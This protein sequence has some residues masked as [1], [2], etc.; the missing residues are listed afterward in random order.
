MGLAVKAKEQ[1]LIGHYEESLSTFRVVESQISEYTSSLSDEME[2]GDPTNFEAA[3]K[4]YSE[5]QRVLALLQEEFALV[6]QIQETC[7][8]FRTL[9]SAPAALA[10]PVDTPPVHSRQLSGASAPLTDAQLQAQ[11]LAAQAAT[12]VRDPDVWPPPTTEAPPPRRTRVSSYG[13]GN[14]SQWSAPAARAPIAA[15]TPMKAP[16]ARETSQDGDDQ[17]S[18][19]LPDWANRK[20]AASAAAPAAAP[21]P[22]P[23]AVRKVSAVPVSSASQVAAADPPP[24][25]KRASMA[26]GA[27]KPAV[28]TVGRRPAATARKGA[29]TKEDEPA[30]EGGRVK[31]EAPTKEEQEMADMIER[32]ILDK[33]PNVKMADI[34]GLAGVSARAR[35]TRSRHPNVALSI[36]MVQC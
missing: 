28:P 36:C 23:K 2:A 26:P 24:R 15:R 20:A 11:H 22:R 31:F 18:A 35:H 1:Y 33:T 3:E 14:P 6:R 16:L 7:A 30:E 5:W 13:G 21:A 34:A 12:D 4:I 10:T 25:T 32:E 29:A 19:R 27:R 17:P 9:P 8:L